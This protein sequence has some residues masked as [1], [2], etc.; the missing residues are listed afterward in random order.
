MSDAEPSISQQLVSS[1]AAGSSNSNS[2]AGA[3][4]AARKP[5][6]SVEPNEKWLGISFSSVRSDLSAS[7][8]HKTGR[9]HVG[10][11]LTYPSA[12][13]NGHSCLEQK[14]GSAVTPA[15]RWQSISRRLLAK[16]LGEQHAAAIEAFEAAKQ[17]RH[18]FDVGV[19]LQVCRRLDST[20]RRVEVG[21]WSRSIDWRNR[22]PVKDSF[23][24][25]AAM[26]LHSEASGAAQST[27]GGAAVT[28]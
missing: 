25:V 28:A 3:V 20:L 14:A 19:S 2:S 26:A 17:K 18:G 16:R 22:R 10:T 9:Q 8:G 7:T 27:E 11:R 1:A 5:M 12:R 6:A 21:R 4:I 13:E 15:L 23:G 24:C